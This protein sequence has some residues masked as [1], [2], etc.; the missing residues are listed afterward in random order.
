MLNNREISEQF[1]VQ[2]NTLYNW[3]KTKPKLYKYLKHADYHKNRNKEIN[4]LFDL[5]SLDIQHNFLYDDIV[6]LINWSF[7][8]VSMEDIKN[9]HTIFIKK[10]YKNIPNNSEQVLQIYNKLQQ[11][12]II[13]KYILYKKIYQFKD[14]NYD[15]QTQLRNHFKEFLQ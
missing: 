14:N 6:Y 5:Y 1:E 9:F 11:L 7:E 2:I 13:E 3:Q 12:N 8:L 4:I 10:Q 15:I